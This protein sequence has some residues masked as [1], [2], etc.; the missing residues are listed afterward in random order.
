MIAFLRKITT[1]LCWS[2]LLSITVSGPLCA[3][4]VGTEAVPAEEVKKSNIK[5]LKMIEKNNDAAVASRAELKK[6]FISR[7]ISE[8]KK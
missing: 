1:P 5:F 3:D 6:K 2:V 7:L 8:M 4:D